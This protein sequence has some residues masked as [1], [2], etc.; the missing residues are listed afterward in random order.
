MSN[1]RDVEYF[2]ILAD[3][4]NF[5]VV[6]MDERDDFIWKSRDPKKDKTWEDVIDRLLDMYGEIQIIEVYAV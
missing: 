6:C 3:D 1:Y 4:S 2:G 5:E